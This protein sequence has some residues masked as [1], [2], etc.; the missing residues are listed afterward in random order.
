MR[1]TIQE[2]REKFDVIFKDPILSLSSLRE[3]TLHNDVCSKTL[4]SV[5]W[6]LFLSYLP[7]LEI[8]AWP[9]ILKNER[10]HYE[11]LRKKYIRMPTT[12][13]AEDLEVNHPLSLKQDNP[14][15]QYFMDSEL[16]KV[17]RQDVER[18]FPEIEY[19]RS[20]EI[21]DRLVDILFVYCKMNQDVS[22]RQGMHELLA[23]ILWVLDT[24]AVEKRIDI[25]HDEDEITQA[26]ETTLD[27]KFAEHD[28]YGLFT[29]LMKSAKTWYEHNDE[30]TPRL[31][32]S[33]KGVDRSDAIDP[34]TRLTPV[35]AEMH[36]IFHKQLKR[37]DPEL[38][39]H[40]WELG[41]EPQLYGIRWLRLLFGREFP[42]ETLV[43]LWDGLFAEDP[44]L[45]LTNY[46]ALIML[47]RIRDQLLHSDYTGCLHLL[48]RYPPTPDISSYI[49]QAIFLRDHFSLEGGASIIQQINLKAGRVTRLPQ[50]HDAAV[51]LPHSPKISS[52]QSSGLESGGRV[53]GARAAGVNLGSGISG[54]LGENLPSLSQVVG[55]RNATAINRAIQSTIADMK[56]N[57]TMIGEHVIRPIIESPPAQHA[58]VRR[59][60]RGRLDEGDFP[61]NLENA[62]IHH[63]ASQAALSQTTKLT[64]LRE[65]NKKMGEAMDRGIRLLEQELFP[66]T[67]SKENGK[68]TDTST[69][70]SKLNNEIG[71]LV[72]LTGLK[73]IRDILLNDSIEFNPHIMDI[74]EPQD[75]SIEAERVSEERPSGE[76]E[77][78]T[79]E[80]KCEALL[81]TPTLPTTAELSTTDLPVEKLQN[82]IRMEK[83]KPLEIYSSQAHPATIPTTHSV[84]TAASSSNSNASNLT[85]NL[86]KSALPSLASGSKP[87]T[88]PHKSPPTSP[89][90]KRTSFLLDEL[91]D[92]GEDH[93]AN[94]SHRESLTRG[95]Y[96]W[97]LG[98]PN[99]ANNLNGKSQDVWRLP[100][101][102]RRPSRRN[103]SSA[104]GA[105]NLS[106]SSENSE[107]RLTQSLIE[108]SKSTSDSL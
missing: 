4:R 64:Q 80:D 71:V 23:P 65:Q 12:E 101:S 47:M 75:K 26:L 67:S 79:A 46:I 25:P 17:I 16:R 3:K 76:W 48:M 2:Q 94:S 49:E 33:S 107:P 72:V 100:S 55:P 103:Y 28:A 85:T 97:M 99:N 66:Q 102:T 95:R 15:Q 20:Q 21:Q 44:T 22:Y 86:S 69:E 51:K 68:S 57:V 43:Q 108:E 84:S 98:E 13:K 45:R 53:S 5:C 11:S 96:S 7:S 40:L 31:R 35:L 106:P 82:E 60:G 6:K 77:V 36:K 38:Y 87:E 90:Q 89:S 74:E 19:F 50:P 18:T 56:K 34:E 58:G 88:Q 39:T 32:K 29:Q 41:I 42:F 105:D 104:L 14:W 8:R 78:V 24:E 1:H 30:V 81:P 52:R 91:L 83:N 37:V 93:G 9:L 54:S 59:G 10:E 27:A 92:T 62:L 63:A 70:R 61:P 73:H